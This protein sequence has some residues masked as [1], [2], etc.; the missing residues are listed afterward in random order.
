VGGVPADDILEVLDEA[1]DI[2]AMKLQGINEA[3]EPDLDILNVDTDEEKDDLLDFASEEEDDFD[4][5]MDNGIQ[6]QTDP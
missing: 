6:N 3:Q 5:G 4:N 1:E 2:I